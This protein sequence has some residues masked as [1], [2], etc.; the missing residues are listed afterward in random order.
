MSVDVRKAVT[1]A[2]YIAVGIV[3]LGV[4]QFNTTR[5]ELRERLTTCG[6]ETARDT[7]RRIGDQAGQARERAV[8]AVR[9]V[10]DQVGASAR[11]AR[12]QLGE[13]RQRV[14]PVVEQVQAR[15]PE[16]VD[17]LRGQARTAVG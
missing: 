7:G 16:P 6:G 17:R 2:G 12:E 3:V 9:D 14:E 10:G 8:R 5:R 11:D 13:L 1:D 15:L 4:Q